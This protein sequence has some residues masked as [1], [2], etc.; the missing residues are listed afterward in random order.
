MKKLLVLILLI[1]LAGCGS[2]NEDPITTY[3]NAL[4]KFNNKESYTADVNNHLTVH[5]QGTELSEDGSKTEKAVEGQFIYSDGKTYNTFTIKP[6]GN[7]IETWFDGNKTYVNDGGEKFY[8]TDT[9]ENYSSNL[10]TFSGIKPVELTETEYSEVEKNDNVYSFK[11]TDEGGYKIF[12]TN[13]AFFDSM[14]SG[15]FVLESSTIDNY[16]VTIES[17]EISKLEVTGIFKGSFQGYPMELTYN[18]TVLYTT[19]G[20]I[21]KQPNIE[22]FQNTDII[23]ENE[24]Q[25]ST[26]GGIVV[27]NLSEFKSYLESINFK[28]TD[29]NLYTLQGETTSFT[30]DFL[31]QK[32]YLIFENI[33]YNYYWTSDTGNTG[34]C[35]YDFKLDS[36]TGECGDKDVH[37]IK[38][39]KK[40][41]LYDIEYL[42]I[43]DYS[44]LK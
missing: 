21:E 42:G 33:E 27:T 41:F 2:V 39:A 35:V 34:S 3:N 15:I 11:L 29:N 44:I 14:T 23:E 19:S 18:E 40:S 38:E 10:S 43:T 28:T 17:D 37:N 6:N 20:S 5:L 26:P 4:E 22:E 1:V 36:T 7:T 25:S 16:K 8:Y 30:Y 31:N 9:F 12:Q 13:K 32:H 24:P